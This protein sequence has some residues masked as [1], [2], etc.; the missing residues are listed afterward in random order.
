MKL[1]FIGGLSPKLITFKFAKS[2]LAQGTC[3]Y[4]IFWGNTTLK[5]NFKF[6]G[7]VLVQETC[8]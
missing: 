2:L 4:C 5:I 7:F 6:A 8:L 3:Y 1:R